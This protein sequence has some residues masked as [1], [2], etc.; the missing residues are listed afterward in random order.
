M[1][2]F[3]VCSLPQ[4]MSLVDAYLFQYFSQKMFETVSEKFQSLLGDS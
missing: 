3:K 2:V 4:V 1:S